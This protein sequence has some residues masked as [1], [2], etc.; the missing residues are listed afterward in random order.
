MTQKSLILL[1]RLTLELVYRKRYVNL[2]QVTRRFNK[3]RSQ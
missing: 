2:I 1:L 3:H